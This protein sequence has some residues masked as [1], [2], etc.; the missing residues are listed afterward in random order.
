[1]FN[2]L[3]LARPEGDA[4]SQKNRAWMR[5]QALP[6][7]ESF[8]VDNALEL[9]EQTEARLKA[10]DARLLAIAS[11]EESAKLLVTIPGVDVT[12]AIALLAAIGDVR[13]FDTPGQLAAYFGL[14]PRVS[15]S[16]GRCHHGGI[17]KTGSSGARSLAIEAAQVVAR[18]SSPLAATYWRVR[19]KRGHNV[20]VTA[21]ARKIIV[22]VWYLLQRREP[23][24]YAPLPR[25]RDKLRRLTPSHHRSIQRPETLDELCREV[26]LPT[27]S[28]PTPAERRVAARNRSTITRLSR[29]LRE[30]RLTNS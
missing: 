12:V 16:A 28:L 25:T 15:Q 5:A 30:E 6:A 1:V 20:A 9:L 7:T 2:R 3:L 4:F 13:R 29:Q 26:G 24:R 8:L 19:R 22:V 21:L 23:Y 11:V 10:V 18:S 17:T 14:V 27:P